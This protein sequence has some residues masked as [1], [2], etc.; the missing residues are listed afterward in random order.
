MPPNRRCRRHY[1]FGLSPLTRPDFSFTDNPSRAVEESLF[2]ATAAAASKVSS[3]SLTINWLVFRWDLAHV[4]PPR[5]PKAYN[6]FGLNMLFFLVYAKWSSTPEWLRSFG[7]GVHQQELR[8]W[9]DFRDP[10][11]VLSKVFL[12]WLTAKSQE[13]QKSGFS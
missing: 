1:L 2:P 12:P 8:C 13:C 3:W 5:S 4:A 11:I 7:T 6:E 10:P 9:L